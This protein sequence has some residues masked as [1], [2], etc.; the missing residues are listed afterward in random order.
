MTTSSVDV[1]S[2]FRASG[3]QVRGGLSAELR[4][5]G[6]LQPGRA[7]RTAVERAAVAHVAVRRA[8]DRRRTRGGTAATATPP[9]PPPPSITRRVQFALLFFICF[10]FT[11]LLRPAPNLVPPPGSSLPILPPTTPPSILPPLDPPRF[12][13]REGWGVRRSMPSTLPPSTVRVRR[14]LLE[15]KA[16]IGRVTR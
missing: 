1:R 9:P 4:R 16:A 14:D 8:A 15:R 10:C 2:L 6:R 5:R 12:I 7:V 3:T 11:R 13:R